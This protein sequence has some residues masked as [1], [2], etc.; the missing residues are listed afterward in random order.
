MPSDRT[1]PALLPTFATRRAERLE[2]EQREGTPAR[3]SLGL[4]V[5]EDPNR[6]NFTITSTSD[7]DGCPV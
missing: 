1:S 5:G 7:A 2:R 6:N 4:P 3:R